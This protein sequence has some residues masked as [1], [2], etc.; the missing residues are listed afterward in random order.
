MLAY[1]GVLRESKVLIFVSTIDEVE[2]F[3]YLLCNLKY[4]DS[5][6]QPTD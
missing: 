1:L 2:F 4:R 6:G 5:N 3:D